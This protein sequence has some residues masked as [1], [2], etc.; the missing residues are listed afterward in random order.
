MHALYY[1]CHCYIYVF[2]RLNH[3][4]VTVSY[5]AVLKLLS[6]ISKRNDV[7]IQRW[8]QES[9]TFKFVGDNVAKL[10]GVR[11]ITSQHQGHLCHMYSLLAVKNR[12][13]PPHTSF[14]VFSTFINRYQCRVTSPNRG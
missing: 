5:N 11:N 7:P 3:F 1:T 9:A 2:T 12:V 14:C 10:K 13:N 6:E 8:I 4:S